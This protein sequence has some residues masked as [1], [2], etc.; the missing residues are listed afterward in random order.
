MKLG[1]TLYDWHVVDKNTEKC[2]DVMN[3]FYCV[4]LKH[5]Q[6]VRENFYNSPENILLNADSELYFFQTYMYIFVP[7]REDG[8]LSEHCIIKIIP[9]LEHLEYQVYKDQKKTFSVNLNKK[10]TACQ[11]V[12]DLNWCAAS[13]KNVIQKCSI[14]KTPNFSLVK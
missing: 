3:S 7:P 6:D 12:L 11:K 8:A 13:I 14:S 4:F 10:E 1:K 2:A 9:A 5:A